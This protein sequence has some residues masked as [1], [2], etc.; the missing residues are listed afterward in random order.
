MIT[1]VPGFGSNCHWSRGEI[2]NLFQMEVKP[3]GYN[4]QFCH[5]LG[6]TSRVAAYE[7]WY[8]L[9]TQIVLGINTVEYFLESFEL[10]EWR[11]A[12]D[13]K[14]SI[15]GMLRRYFQFLLCFCSLPDPYSREVTNRILHRCL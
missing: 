7:V 11:F 10:F 2:L 5:V 3:F 13:V 8:D 4:S 6:R 15:T 12:H 9:L 1:C 14:Y